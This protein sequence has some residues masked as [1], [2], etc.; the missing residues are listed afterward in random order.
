MTG[1]PSAFSSTSGASSAKA[2]SPVCV[3]LPV[4]VSTNQG[5]AIIETRV[6]VREIASDVSQP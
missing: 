1:P 6:P 3:A 5:R 2:T 4:V